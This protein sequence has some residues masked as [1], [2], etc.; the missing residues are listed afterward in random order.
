MQSAG[1]KPAT[2]I[3]V[4]DGKTAQIYTPKIV[5]HRIPLAGNGKHRHKKETHALEL[6]PI[7][8]KPLMA[9]SSTIY[10]MGRNQT[11]MVF[12]SAGGARHMSEPHIDAR[13]EVKQCFAQR[14]ADLLNRSKMGEAFDRLVLAA[15]PMMLGEI[16][17]RLD[18]NIRHK[19]TATL[20][21]ELTHLS[22][23]KLIAHLNDAI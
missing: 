23:H 4:A 16:E 2:W 17:L 14:I 9:E 13:K 11:G 3:L 1:K 20:P 8:A 22:R 6:A 19:V 5:E 15:P 21:K 18:D 10:Q 12:E 7:L